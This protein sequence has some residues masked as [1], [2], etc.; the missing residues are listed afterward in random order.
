MLHDLII[1][2]ENTKKRGYSLVKTHEDVYFQGVKLP[3]MQSLDM[4]L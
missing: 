3:D 1:G 4:S 2:L